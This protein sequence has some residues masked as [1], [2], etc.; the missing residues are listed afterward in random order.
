MAQIEMHRDTALGR[1]RIQR[2]L[3]D[4]LVFPLLR[5]KRAPRGDAVRKADERSG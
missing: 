2:P 1:A 5:K 4:E 3:K